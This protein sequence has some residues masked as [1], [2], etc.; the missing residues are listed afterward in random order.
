MSKDYYAILGV[1]K[2]SGDAEIKKA[3]RK[4]AH[5]YHPDKAGGDEKKFKEINE[6]YQVLSDKT[7]KNQY[8]QFGQTFESGGPG[9]QGN[10]SGFEGFNFDFSN[11]GDIFGDI[12]GSTRNRRKSS[13][14]QDISIDINLTFEESIFGIEKEIELYKGIICPRC[15]GNKAEPGTPIKTCPTCQGKGT[16]RT[17][18]QTFLGSFTQE[19][20]CP[21]CRGEGKRAEK[22]CRE[23]GGDGRVRDYVKL[24]IKIPEGIQNGQT[25]RLSGQGE[26]FP[27]GTSGDLFVNVNVSPHRFFKRKGWDI[28][29]E[30]PIT[31]S[32]AILGDKIEIPTVSGPVMLKIP[33]KTQP[34]QIIK[35]RG[36]GVGHR[37]DQYIIIKIAPNPSPSFKEKRL[38]KE[39]YETEKPYREKLLDQFK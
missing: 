15:K 31:Y 13:R 14:G 12:F 29:L 3:Y 37:G 22:K 26:A 32:Q 2:E 8:D 16:Q 11:L 21:D 28:F 25:L 19:S 1:S 27:G 7:K 20:V 10:A 35:L 17:T 9:F 39:L 6:A 30:L 4:L 23:C 18:R 34:D 33:K 36:K 24:N 5:K 38:L